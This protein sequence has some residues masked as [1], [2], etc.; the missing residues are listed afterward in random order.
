MGK[1]PSYYEELEPTIYKGFKLRTFFNW[2]TD[3]LVV[4]EKKGRKRVK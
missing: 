1:I 2:K 3:K 4:W